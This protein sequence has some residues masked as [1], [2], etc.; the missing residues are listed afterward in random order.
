LRRRPEALG[1]V[2]RLLI[3][4]I[5]GLAGGLRGVF[6]RAHPRAGLLG[7]LLDAIKVLVGLV[8]NVLGALR[9]LLDRIGDGFRALGLR[10]FERVGLLLQ[11]L[12]V[13]SLGFRARAE[14]PP[15]S[16]PLGIPNGSGSTGEDGPPMYCR[17][18]SSGDATGGAA[19]VPAYG[20]SL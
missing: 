5:H 10:G 19:G 9:V 16:L 1:P 12:A 8:A 3:A 11:A 13:A 7:C 18:T 17:A 20:W 14:C 15:I 2:Q 4:V 6:N